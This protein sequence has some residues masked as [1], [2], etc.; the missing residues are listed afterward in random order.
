M[1]WLWAF[2]GII[3]IASV[4][5]IILFVIPSSDVLDKVENPES[6][7]EGGG[8]PVDD[9]VIPVNWVAMRTSSEEPSEMNFYVESEGE[10]TEHECFGHFAING[11]WMA[12][13]APG[14]KNAKGRVFVYN[15]SGNGWVK[16]QVLVGS[17]SD[18][19]HEFGKRI[20][21]GIDKMYVLSPMSN[22]TQSCIYEYTLEG[23]KW[24]EGVV[25]RNSNMFSDNA[26]L[27]HEGWL[28]AT[29]AGGGLFT[30]HSDWADE[31]KII[32]ENIQIMDMCSVDDE[33]ILVT[34]ANGTKLVNILNGG[35]VRQ[36]TTSG[37][38][39]LCHANLVI[40]GNSET[41][42][43]HAMRLDTFAEIDEIGIPGGSL[44]TFSNS[45][46]G[47]SICYDKI[48]TVYVSA[49][50][51]NIGRFSEVGNV[52]SF[53]FENGFDI[54]GMIKPGSHEHNLL[55]YGEQIAI[56]DGKLIVS[57][58]GYDNMNGAVLYENITD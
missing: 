4:V 49:P 31:E 27:V 40:V 33:H 58:R 52:W 29:I 20:V 42:T 41:E 9:S 26:M 25:Y 51:D 19:F 6:A 35:V 36:S 1:N 43:I 3:I 8:G 21:F 10:L 28:I 24:V 50:Y 18:S 39:I 44:S 13:G 56:H 15:K 37:N 14:W 32:L 22:L 55:H 45:G 46:F 11:D 30:H 17:G 34:S 23:G 38:S 16:K 47:T 12:V 7:R 2:V 48:G 54:T 57:A 53:K 5:L